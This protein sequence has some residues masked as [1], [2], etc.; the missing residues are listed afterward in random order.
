MS[1]TD[2]CRGSVPVAPSTSFFDFPLHILYVKL[3][4]VGTYLNLIPKNLNHTRQ[5]RGGG[6]V[7]N[8]GVTINRAIVVSYVSCPF[9]ERF[10]C[11]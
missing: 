9:V 10:L 8:T 7:G 4:Y 5:E 2:T 3:L 11:R 6:G 1:I